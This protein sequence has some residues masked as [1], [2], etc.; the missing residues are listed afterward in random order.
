[1]CM[2]SGQGNK[3]GPVAPPPTDTPTAPSA[4]AP[5]APDCVPVTFAAAWNVKAV[6]NTVTKWRGLGAQWDAGATSR[7]YLAAGDGSAEHN[8]EDTDTTALFRLRTRYAAA[9]VREL[10]HALVMAAGALRVFE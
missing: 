8:A 2:G 5:M 4:R 1:P 7:E 10:D 6:G 9:H 3:G